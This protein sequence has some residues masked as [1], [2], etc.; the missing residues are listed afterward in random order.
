MPP[1]V[2]ALSGELGAG[3]TRLAQAICE[4]YGVRDQVTS[5]TFALIHRYESARSPV[6]HVDLYRLKGLQESAALGLEEILADAALA[7][8]EWPDRAAALLPPG[9]TRIRLEHVADDAGKRR[10]AVEP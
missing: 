10:I 8:V 5:P 9:T 1:H 2:I 6:Y 4:G 3:K 7:I